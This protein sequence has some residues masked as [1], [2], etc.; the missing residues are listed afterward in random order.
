MYKILEKSD[1]TYSVIDSTD[2]VIESI[3]LSD[4]IY[5]VVNGYSIEGV[6]LSDGYLKIDCDST[7]VQYKSSSKKLITGIRRMMNCGRMATVVEDLGSAN[8]KVQ[9]DDGVFKSATRASF[10]KGLI[11]HPDCNVKDYSKCSTDYSVY[12]ILGQRKKMNCGYYCTVIEDNNAQDIT[13]KFDDGAIVRGRH[14]YHFNNGSILHPSLSNTSIL[15][16]RKKMNCGL[17]AT[18]IED[19]GT[20]NI[21]V[22]FENGDVVKNRTRREFNR[23]NIAPNGLRGLAQVKSH[24]HERALMKNGLWAE[25]VDYKSSRDIT[26][27]F[28]VDG[29]TVFHRGLSD[30]N[31]GFI[32]HPD[33]TPYALSNLLG[34]EKMM[35]CGLVAKVIKDNRVDDIDVKFSDGFI[36]TGRHR[37]EFL[38]GNICHPEYKP[39]VRN[40][41]KGVSKQMRNGLKA[42]VIRD[43]GAYDID[44]MFEDGYIV[45]GRSRASF[46]SGYIRHPEYTLNSLPELLVY[47]YVLT[48]FPDAIHN[49]RPDWLKN[50]NTGKN[51]ELDIWIPSLSI[52]IEYDGSTFHS[53]KTELSELKF[54]LIVNSKYI[55]KIYTLLEPDCVEHSSTK[56]YNIRLPLKSRE[57]DYLILGLQPAIQELL[58]NLGVS[59]VIDFNYD[60]EYLSARG[61]IYEKS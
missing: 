61:D 15:G 22:K 8:I 16:K 18:V 6:T 25:I 1:F 37:Y 34:Q 38:N 36:V 24:L 32:S 17:F 21:S 49:Y 33:Y 23:G 3:L 29:Y 57:K 39:K 51:L 20:A 40:S 27:R 5:L 58:K 28:D 60:Y 12:S 31:R 41:L 30:F 26:V 14:R 45:Y 7:V 11:K 19:G 59:R 56:H 43:N 46:E 9:F 54:N 2:G 47:K 48:S 35:K 55:N 10:N 50:I 52:G 53:S 44:I 42:T 4:I 13:V